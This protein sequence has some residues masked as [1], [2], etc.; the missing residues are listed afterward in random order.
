M[1]INIKSQILNCITIEITNKIVTISDFKDAISNK[2][3]I[4]KNY[5]ILMYDGKI[6]ND[7]NQITDYNIKN[8]DTIIMHYIIEQ[9]KR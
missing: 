4:S 2:K 1:I 5:M 6:L 3:N 9:N 8:D 7:D